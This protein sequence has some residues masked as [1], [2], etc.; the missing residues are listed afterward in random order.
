M[1][2]RIANALGVCLTASACLIG[3]AAWRWG[4]S[5]PGPTVALV[6]GA[7]QALATINRPCAPGPCG[8]LA[9]VDKTVTKV[10]D[11]IVTTQMQERAIAP[12][13]VAAVDALKGSADALTTTA[14]AATQSVRG[15]SVSAD[16]LTGTLTAATGTLDA[17]K[18]PIHAF[19]QDAV[20]LG[21]LLKDQA[22]HQTMSNVAAMTD[23]GNKML[24]DAQWKEHQL[25]H[26]DKVKLG[27]W[28]SVWLAAK[29]VHQFEPPLF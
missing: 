26:P 8:T 25:L 20:D 5:A 23:S 17:A 22:I 7:T 18:A 12:H 27:F 6:Q 4:L 24:A 19:T 10:G 14:Q 1:N 3:W 16:A 21:A 28:G 9:I 2:R 13:T 11:A 15:I 29:Y